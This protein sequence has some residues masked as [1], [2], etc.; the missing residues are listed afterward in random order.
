[1]ISRFDPGHQSAIPTP[2]RMQVETA[3]KIAIRN[4][5][6][7]PL[8][9]T[10]SRYRNPVVSLIYSHHRFDGGLAIN[11]NHSEEKVMKS[12]LTRR[13]RKAPAHSAG[14]SKTTGRPHDARIDTEV[15]TAVIRPL[16]RGGYDAVTIDGI[17]NSVGR[18]RS[19]LYR[20]WPFGCLRGGRRTRGEPCCGYRNTARRS[21][22][23]MSLFYSPPMTVVDRK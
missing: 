21:G 2:I 4:T 11:H 7:D 1:M 5:P 22:L 15:I 8:L 20:R 13:K 3:K 9:C 16:H 19:S 10:L 17:A 23:I 14:S 12:S 6:K 18:A